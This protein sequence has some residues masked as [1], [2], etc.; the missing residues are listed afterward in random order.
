MQKTIHIGREEALVHWN[1]SFSLGGGFQGALWHIFP[2][3]VE[4]IVL[5]CNDDEEITSL[6]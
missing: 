1:K 3:R 4:S 2:F 6:L 5:I